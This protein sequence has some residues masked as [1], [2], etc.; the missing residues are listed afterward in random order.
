[1]HRWRIWSRGFNQS[2]LI[3]GHLVRLTAQP[4]LVDGLMRVR[5]TRSLAGLGRKAR[6]K[7]LRAA[8]RVNPTHRATLRGR[9]I[10][11]VDDVY[12]SGATAD[13]CARA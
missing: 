8:I 1:M 7:E 11:L 9:H 6:A 10:L 12:T 4:M 2:A 13:A 5:A 3:A